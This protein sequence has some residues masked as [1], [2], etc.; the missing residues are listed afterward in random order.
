VA[1]PRRLRDR[2]DVGGRGLVIPRDLRACLLLCHPGG[3][4]IAGRLRRACLWTLPSLGGDR[5]LRLAQPALRSGGVAFAPGTSRRSP[6]CSR[7]GWCTRSSWSISAFPRA[8]LRSSRWPRLLSRWRVHRVG[9]R[10]VARAAA[11]VVL[12]VAGG[13]RC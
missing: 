6:R 4:A 1:P 12:R 2:G 13:V 5:V 8:V 3:G 11:A 10:P 7:S 9:A